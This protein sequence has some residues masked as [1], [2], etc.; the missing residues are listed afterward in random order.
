MA[1]SAMRRDDVTL[2]AL[3]ADMGEKSSED[4]ACCAPL[5]RGRGDEL[6]TSDGSQEGEDVEEGED[7]K[8]LKECFT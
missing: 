7:P 2:W 6:R 5:S 3:N 4:R 1:F 8:K